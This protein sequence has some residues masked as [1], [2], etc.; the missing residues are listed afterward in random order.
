MCALFGATIC[1]VDPRL[2]SSVSPIDVSL[3]GRSLRGTRR[4]TFLESLLIMLRF[5][6]FG[7]EACCAI[8]AGDDYGCRQTSSAC[9]NYAKL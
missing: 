5:S 6:S 9:S 4:N 2:A 3:D 1:S 7:C 8:Q